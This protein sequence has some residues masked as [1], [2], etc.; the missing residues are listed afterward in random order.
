MGG[1]AK[2]KLNGNSRGGGSRAKAPVNENAAENEQGKQP[3]LV[4][5]TVF[6]IVESSSGVQ[7]PSQWLS[8]SER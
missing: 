5:Q 4:V 6:R 8:V 7:C 2:M 1:G 3:Q